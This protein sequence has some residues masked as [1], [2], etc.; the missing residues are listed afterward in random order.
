MT[1]VRQAEL[2]FPISLQTAPPTPKARLNP[3]SSGALAAQKQLCD[4][5]RVIVMKDGLLVAVAPELTSLRPAV[6]VS[7]PPRKNSR[8]P[9]SAEV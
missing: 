2:R 4:G 3:L 6:V 9:G 5:F 8:I 7:A 1:D